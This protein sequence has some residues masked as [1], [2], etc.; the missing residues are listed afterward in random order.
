MANDETPG[1]KPEESSDT[2]TRASAGPSGVTVTQQQMETEQDRQQQPPRGRGGKITVETNAPAAKFT[3]RGPATY[4]GS[5]T[6]FDQDDAPAGTYTITYEAVPGFVTPAVEAKTLPAG[7]SILFRGTYTEQPGAVARFI[8]FASY[9]K[10]VRR[11]ATWTLVSLIFGL[12]CAALGTWPNTVSALLWSAA[13]SAV[14]WVLGFLFG[15]P[16]TLQTEGQSEVTQTERSVTARRT[17]GVNTNLEQISDWLTK[18]LVGVT[19]VQLGTVTDR[20][21]S[22]AVLIAESLGGSNMKSFAYA[23]MVYFAL[24]GFLG[25]YL[26]TRLFLQRIFEEDIEARNQ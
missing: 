12:L 7:G 17:T 11:V 23:L 21:D 2:T 22:A 15:I 26:L 14:G 24:T 20:L 10:N 3:I 13:C 19:L 1:G 4:S 8:G 25:S 16:R 5:G 6:A 18:I 9:D